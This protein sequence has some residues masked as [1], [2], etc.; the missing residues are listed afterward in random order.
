[1]KTPEQRTIERLGKRLRQR[2]DEIGR[3]KKALADER[4]EVQR[5][6]KLLEPARL[7]HFGKGRF[8]ST[9]DLLKMKDFEI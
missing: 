3:L 7:T 8:V 9:L 2:D 5:L 6:A 1:M 4:A